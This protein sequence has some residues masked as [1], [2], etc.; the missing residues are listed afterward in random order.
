M[1]HAFER[2]Q[3]NKVYKDWRTKN[4]SHTLSHAFLMLHQQYHPNWQFGFYSPETDQVATFI[5]S[6]DNVQFTPE[7]EVFK[8]P[9]KKILPITLSQV[10]KTFDEAYAIA[11]QICRQRCSGQTINSTIAVL[12][13]THEHGIVWNITL[14]TMAFN[15]VNV[16]IDAET[17][18]IKKVSVDSLMGLGT[19]VGPDSTDVLPQ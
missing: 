19:R 18:D 8:D 7:T 16:K 1:K 4:P 11:E 9:D 3:Q 2:L 12:Q 5:I 10:K 13:N 17:G 15:T 6:E 14:V